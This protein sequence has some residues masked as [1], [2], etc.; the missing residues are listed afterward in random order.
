[1]T[2]AADWDADLFRLLQENDDLQHPRWCD[3]SLCT[4]ERER[5]GGELTGFHLSRPIAAVATDE[6]VWNPADFTLAIEQWTGGPA[7]VRLT[8]SGEDGFALVPLAA[9]DA[10]ALVAAL[11]AAA[12]AV[13]R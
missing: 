8:V 6:S 12:Q 13:T 1:V 2:T 7:T 10:A 9:A 11:T 5:I 4:V 3:L